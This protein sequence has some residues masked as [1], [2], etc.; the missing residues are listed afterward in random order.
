MTPRVL[1]L[2]MTSALLLASAMAIAAPDDRE[3]NRREAW[4]RQLHVQLDRSDKDIQVLESRLFALQNS[5]AG[6]DADREKEKQA[7]RD[8]IQRMDH[9]QEP[10][11]KCLEKLEHDEPLNRISCPF[12]E[13]SEPT[14]PITMAR[15]PE[16]P[17][18]PA[19]AQAPAPPPPQMAPPPAPAPAPPPGPVLR[20]ADDPAPYEKA[21]ISRVSMFHYNP[22]R[23]VPVGTHQL[24]VYNTFDEAYLLDLAGDCPG[25]LTTERIR[26][27]NFSTK[28]VIGNA[29]IADG[30]RC[31]ITGIRELSVNRLSR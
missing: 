13:D 25:L 31:A 7:L 19:P 11:E 8:Q 2:A 26:I 9:E 29:V 23:W 3:A 4:K 21:T 17:A 6:N 18:V 30:E 20:K 22:Y 1:S 15:P 27:E 28:V 5:H 16:P 10:I 14:K 24:A 12:H